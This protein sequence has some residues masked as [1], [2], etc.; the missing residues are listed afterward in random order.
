VPLDLILIDAN[1]GAEI[2]RRKSPFAGLPVFLWTV[3]NA[4]GDLIYAGFGASTTDSPQTIRTAV[5][6]A[7]T[8]D[9]VREIAVTNAFA[10]AI[11]PDNR[12]AAFLSK[13]L[14]GIVAERV[15]VSW[16]DLQNNVEL[17]AADLG[18][19]SFAIE[20]TGLAIALASAPL[21]PTLTATRSN[22][23]VT[24]SWTLPD[25]SPS[26]T[27]FRLDA[28]NATGLSNLVS[29]SLAGTQTTITV[30]NVPSGTYFVRIHAANAQ[31]FGAAS[32][33]VTISVP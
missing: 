9:Y 33:E 7:D 15:R 20:G 30:P 18:Y 6:R 23:D 4:A 11:S 25:H 5:F 28:G 16:F 17:G 31:G 32:N 29:L 12:H 3:A 19:R 13:R 21:A 24:V 26:A 10:A 27:G 22:N 2:A 14:D 1:T 8:L